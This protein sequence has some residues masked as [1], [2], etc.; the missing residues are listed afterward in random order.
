MNIKI[1][2]ISTVKIHLSYLCT[3]I[4]CSLQ[5]IRKIIILFLIFNFSLMLT[6]ILMSKYSVYNMIF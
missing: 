5:L 4:Y 2:T 6:F 1:G 3:L